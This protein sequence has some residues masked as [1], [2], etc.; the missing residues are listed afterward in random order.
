MVSGPGLQTITQE[1][2]LDQR[3]GARLPLDVTL[4]D[5]TGRSVRL[6]EFY[7]DRPVVF[8]CAYYRCPMLCTQVLNGMLKSANALNL[9]LGR[10]YQIVTLS[11]DP[12][13]TWQE[14]A[15]KHQVYVERYRR[16]GGAAGWHFLT[17][18]Q[19]AIQALTQAIGFRYRYDEGSDQYAHASGVVVTT[20]EGRVS[21]YFYGID[22]P[23]RDLRLA[24]V[25]SSRNAIGSAVDQILLLCFHYD[26]ITGRYGLV[27]ARALR[28][29][30][31]VTLLVLGTYLIR[32]YALERRRMAQASAESTAAR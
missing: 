20:P 22:Y 16:P 26:P 2:G 31:V 30:G 8:V 13:E 25:E 5:H 18:D 21:H 28:L 9:E 17:G 6:S 19:D 7:G 11:I 29:A 1:V 23:P 3:L 14:A 24:L 32:M 4:I 10:D 27:F 12:R 15:A